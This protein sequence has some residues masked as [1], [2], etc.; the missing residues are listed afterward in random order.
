MARFE[1]KRT[2]ASMHLVAH[3]VPTWFIIHKAS[4]GTGNSSPFLWKRHYTLNVW[5]PPNLR[6]PSTSIDF[7]PKF[8]TH[9]GL[10]YSLSNTCWE[11]TLHILKKFPSGDRSVTRTQLLSLRLLG[12]KQHSA[13]HLGLANQRTRKGL[14]TNV[15]KTNKRYL[16]FNLLMTT[17]RSFQLGSQEWEANS[18]R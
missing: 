18:K 3:S 9:W 6:I 16:L 4:K 8:E 14:F 13:N 1:L 15:A 2:S 10:T 11:W 17:F 5:F 12:G 7:C